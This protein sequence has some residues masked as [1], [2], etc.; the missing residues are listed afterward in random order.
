MFVN[1]GLFGFLGCWSL[2][3]AIGRMLR[4]R[5]TDSAAV[6]VVIYGAGTAGAGLAKALAPD[7]TWRVVSFIDDNPRLQGRKV[8]DL[9]VRS[10]EALDELVGR[11]AVEAV[12]L[13]LHS[14][15]PAVRR[16]IL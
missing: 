1:F 12:F 13:A 10:P 9:P 14:V 2:R 4:S 5:A 3:L 8:M 16:G 11:E 6:R 15:A 7:P